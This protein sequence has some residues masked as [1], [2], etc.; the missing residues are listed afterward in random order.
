M[1]TLSLNDSEY[2][3]G[4]CSSGRDDRSLRSR[5]IK[6]E[7]LSTDS[8]SEHLEIVHNVHISCRLGVPK[9]SYN[10]VHREVKR[11]ISSFLIKRS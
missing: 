1:F 8:L 3:S 9:A 6:D 5:E 4:Q 11:L 10:L 2:Y 7:F